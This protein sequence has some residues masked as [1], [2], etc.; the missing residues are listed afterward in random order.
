MAV[1]GTARRHETLAWSDT[2]RDP[3][4]SHTGVAMTVTPRTF[5]AVLGGVALFAGLL[6]TTF[7]PVTATY[8]GGLLG[9]YD[10][11]TVLA[12]RPRYQGE[13]LQACM[14]ALSTR[15]AWGWTLVIVGVVVLA[16]A[17]LVRSPK[18]SAR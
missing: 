5:A 10:C 16:A 1:M 15:G 8:P 6:A 14:D 4:L 13:P 3:S 17:L 18:Q 12:S 7:V 11:G 2:P 9:E